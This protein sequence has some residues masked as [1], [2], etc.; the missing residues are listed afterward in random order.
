MKKKSESLRFDWSVSAYRV[1]R[2]AGRGVNKDDSEYYLLIIYIKLGQIINISSSNN[3][4][5]Y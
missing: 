2:Y 3:I 5:I 1:S 4:K